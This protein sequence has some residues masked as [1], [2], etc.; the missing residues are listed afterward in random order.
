MVYTQELNA[1]LFEMQAEIGFKSKQWFDGKI[2]FAPP[3]K[4][5]ATQGDSHSWVGV[6]IICKAGKWRPWFISAINTLLTCLSGLRCAVRTRRKGRRVPGIQS[7]SLER[8]WR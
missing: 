5:L 3:V 6:S 7:D 8:V 1:S 2:D 4:D